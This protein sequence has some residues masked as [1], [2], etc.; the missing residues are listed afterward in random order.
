MEFKHIR[1]SVLILFEK[2]LMLP[3]LIAIVIISLLV[4]DEF[5][6]G[7][8]IP[9]FLLTLS[10]ISGFAKYISTYYT[11]E[12]GHLIVETGIFYKKRL[13]IPF[14]QITTV[15]LSQNLIYQLFQTYRIK[16]DNASQSI[17]SI[18]KAEVLLALKKDKALE[19]KKLLTQQAASKMARLENTSEIKASP[20]DFI[21][22]GFLQSKL[23]YFCTG[24]PIAVPAIAG[25]VAFITGAKNLDELLDRI[26]N[27]IPPGIIIMGMITFFYLIALT[28]S[29][30][31]SLFTYYNFKIL[32]D[33][34]TLRIEYGLFDK[35]KFT[36]PKSKVNGILLKQNLLMRVFKCYRVEVL[37]IGYGDESDGEVHRLPIIYPVASIAKV[38]SI[39]R[40][41]FM[42]YVLVD[43]LHQPDRK[44]IRYFFY[45]AGF[46]ISII[47]F[48]GSLFTKDFITIILAGILAVIAVISTILQYFSAGIFCG[49]N[50]IILSFGGYHKTIA[51][52]KTVN[53]ENITANSNLL[54]RKKDIVSITVGFL[55]PFPSS[56]MTVPN[57]PAEHFRS[58]EKVI[59]Y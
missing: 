53:I 23:L 27:V 41:L 5:N 7:L 2:L 32:S 20:L 37:V 14:H 21:K 25:I 34:D 43:K 9:I 40:E 11:L 29:L 15:D 31:S 22:L 51:L 6:A 33:A 28:V 17:D 52:I 24:G 57:L 39:F 47:I 30:F 45:H 46:V 4:Y 18:N 35:K 13:D 12:D 55:A 48:S 26:F 36:L 10:P 59:R 38:K 50:N 3:G 49:E 8:I 56:I 19:F 54:K 44:A 42:D 58:L 1:G 16:V